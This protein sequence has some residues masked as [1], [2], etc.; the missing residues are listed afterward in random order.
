LDP[1]YFSRDL[2]AAQFIFEQNPQRHI[3]VG[4][5]ID[6]FV[7]HIA[8]FRPIEVCEMRPIKVANKNIKTLNLNLTD[9]AN[10]PEEIC[11][12]VSSLHVLEHIGLGRYGDELNPDGWLLGIKNL[13]RM[14]KWGGYLY[15][16]V[17]VDYQ[18]LEFDRNRIFDVETICNAMSELATL[19]EV[20]LISSSESSIPFGKN[21][22]AAS[23]ASKRFANA[24]LLIIAIKE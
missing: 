1:H 21:F 14:L 6:G 24:C 19:D 12:S 8:T 18:R 15:V 16:S 11:N 17:P 5:R 3:D 10:V 13:L 9:T 2:L 4:S 7:V 22:A 20:I 23:E